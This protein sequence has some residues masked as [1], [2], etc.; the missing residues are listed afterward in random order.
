ME[1]KKCDESK[2]SV[3]YTLVY[4]DFINEEFSFQQEVGEEELLT[5]LLIKAKTGNAYIKLKSPEDDDSLI[6]VKALYS[7]NKTK[8]ESTKP[9]NNGLVEYRM[10]DYSNAELTFSPITCPNSNK[11]C[12][13]EF[14]YSYISS[15]EIQNVYA[16]LMCSSISFDLLDRQIVIPSDF[17]PISA[18]TNKQNKVQ[19]NHQ[20]SQNTDFIGIRAVNSKTQEI[21]YYRPIELMTVLG[22]ISKGTKGNGFI[23]AVVVLV[24]ICVCLII[25]RRMFKSNKSQYAPLGN[26]D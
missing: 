25:S 13:K 2:L 26:F 18:S 6:T 20:I 23:V 22:Q 3:G 5:Q 9:G 14:A 17:K 24:F 10:I 16:Q 11:N 12:H 1:I 8:K 15:Q 21:V 4:D 19:L 7:Y